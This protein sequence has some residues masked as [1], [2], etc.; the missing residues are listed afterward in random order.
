MAIN[1]HQMC[2]HSQHYTT[3]ALNCQPGELITYPIFLANTAGVLQVAR[4]RQSQGAHLE[5][6]VSEHVGQAE[7]V[8]VLLCEGKIKENR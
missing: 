8:V 4:P 1:S 7:L 3:M 5:I 2:L 6:S